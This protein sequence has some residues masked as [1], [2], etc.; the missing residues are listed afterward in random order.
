M[1]IKLEAPSAMA[2]MKSWAVLVE[3]RHRLRLEELQEVVELQLVA[4]STVELQSIKLE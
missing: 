1:M 3:D 2:K 4:V